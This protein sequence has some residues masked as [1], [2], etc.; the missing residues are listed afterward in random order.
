[1]SVWQLHSGLSVNAL[2][3]SHSFSV[4]VF[5]E[6]NHHV[7]SSLFNSTVSSSEYCIKL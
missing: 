1:M 2:Y 6:H 4:Y 3:F 5:Q 7:V